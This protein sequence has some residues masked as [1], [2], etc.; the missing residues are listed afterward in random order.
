MSAIFKAKKEG[1]S[2]SAKGSAWER[3]STSM[4]ALKK[5]VPSSAI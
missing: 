1:D 3:E 5:C 4:K 2:A